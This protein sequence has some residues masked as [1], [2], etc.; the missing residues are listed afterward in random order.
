M[1]QNLCFFIHQE[2]INVSPARHCNLY[3]KVN[4]T[5]GLLPQS[6]AHEDRAPPRAAN[7]LR[8]VGHTWGLELEARRPLGCPSGQER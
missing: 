8:A 2:E 7:W 1:G 4:E 3:F 6:L 5:S